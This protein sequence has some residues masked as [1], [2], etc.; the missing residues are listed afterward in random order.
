MKKLFLCVATILTFAGCKAKVAKYEIYSSI[1]YFQDGY[2]CVT[3]NV[4]VDENLDEKNLARIYKDV[5]NTQADG[6]YKHTV[7]FYSSK[8]AVSTE[9]YDV[10]E[11]IED[12]GNDYTFKEAE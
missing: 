7:D 3:Y 10:A 1:M 9:K 4:I 12:S 6:L 11:I 2:Q 5:I 8:D